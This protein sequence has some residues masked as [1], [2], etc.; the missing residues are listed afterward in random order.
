MDRFIQHPG[1]PRREHVAGHRERQPEVVVRTVRAH[2]ATRGGMPPVLDIA[3]P[4]LT[5]R[6]Q[7]QVLAR[8]RSRLQELEKRI[9]ELEEKLKKK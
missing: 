3:I 7:E 8:T 5:G 2:A 4:E 9:A 1:I 6:A